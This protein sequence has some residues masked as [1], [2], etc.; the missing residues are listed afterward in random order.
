MSDTPTN[1]F[2]SRIQVMFG[3]IALALVMLGGFWAA[4]YNP[5]ADR[6]Q[7]QEWDLNKRITQGAFEEYRTRIDG[8]LNRVDTTIL[9]MDAAVVPR[10]EHQGKWNE[11][12]LQLT[13]LQKQ[14]DEMRKEFGGTYSLRDAM[15]D[16]QKRIDRL[17]G[18]QRRDTVPPPK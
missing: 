18:W 17:E 14:I 2:A 4:V 9:R 8:T 15:A 13:S 6:L 3:G 5:L 11:T 1:G 16:Q 12:T 7:R 10:G